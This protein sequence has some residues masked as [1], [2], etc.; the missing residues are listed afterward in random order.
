RRDPGR[1]PRHGGLE[2]PRILLD[3]G[4]KHAGMTST[5]HPGVILA[6]IQGAYFGYRL[7][8]MDAGQVH[9]GMTIILLRDAG[10]KHAG[11]TS[12]GHPGV[13]LAG[14]QI[15]HFRIHSVCSWMPA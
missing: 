13:I 5:G 14:V 4:L 10:H 7:Q 8:L 12:T 2:S 11:M 6:G 9:A 15:K 1:G 3:A